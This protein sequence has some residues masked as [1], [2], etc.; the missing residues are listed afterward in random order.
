M[1]GKLKMQ[2]DTFQYR[3]TSHILSVKSFAQ[4]LRL[5]LKNVFFNTYFTSDGHANTIISRPACRIIWCPECWKWHFRASRFQ[6]FQ[7]P[8]R[9]TAPCSY[10]RLLFSNQLPTSNFIDTPGHSINFSA[11]SV[12]LLK[13]CK[14]MWFN[15]QHPYM[16]LGTRRTGNR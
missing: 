13:L 7:T 10:S 6:N 9:L 16:P 11:A 14:Q 12:M 1:D 5:Q 2:L 3:N 4:Y 15:R 8:P